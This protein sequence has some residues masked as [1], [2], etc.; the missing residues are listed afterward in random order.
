ME[1]HKKQQMAHALSFLQL[2][3]VGGQE[4]EN[5]ITGDKAFAYHHFRDKTHQ[6]E[7]EM[8]KFTATKDTHECE[9]QLHSDSHGILSVLLTDM[10]QQCTT[11]NAAP[12]TAALIC[13]HMVIKQKHSRLVQG[14]TLSRQPSKFGNNS[15]DRYCSI[16]HY[17]PWQAPTQQVPSFPVLKEHLGS[18]IF[19]FK[20]TPTWKQQ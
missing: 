14:H 17:S 18:H 7:M 2:Y 16:L 5:V 1:D 9:V 10:M 11:L 19:N 13:L 15:H 20:V 3:S 12:Y 8:Y 6:H 4:F